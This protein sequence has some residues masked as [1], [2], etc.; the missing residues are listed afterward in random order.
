LVGHRVLCQCALHRREI[1]IRTSHR[2]FTCFTQY[3]RRISPKS[4]GF[5]PLPVRA[6]YLRMNISYLGHILEPTKSLGFC[7]PWLISS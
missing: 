4:P 3:S 1:D 5:G 2:Y 6:N 7:K